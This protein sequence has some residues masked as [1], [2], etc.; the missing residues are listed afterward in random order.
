MSGPADLQSFLNPLV[1]T[2]IQVAIFA[3][4]ILVPLFLVLW[5]WKTWVV[6]VRA[7]FFSSQKYVV[8]ELKIPK[9]ISK[10]PLAMELFI[11]SLYQTGGEGTPYDKFWL[12][13][14]RPWFSLEIAS[15][16]GQVRFFIW[17]RDSFRNLIESQLYGQ[18]PDIEI[19]KVEDYSSK[20]NFNWADHDM[21]ACDFKKAAATHLPI[22]TYVNYGLDKDPKEEV[23]IDPITS[24]LEFLGSIG[25]GEQVWIQIVIRAHKKEWIK[26]GTWFEKVDWSHAA[27]LDIDKI[28]KRDDK[29]KKE[30]EINLADFS[31]TKGER[32]KV[33]AIEK[34][35][36][37]LPFDSG[38]RVLYVARKDSYKGGV[39]PG[40]AGSFRQ[41]NAPNLNGFAPENSTSYDY[42]WQ[43]F[44]GVRTMKKKEKMMFLYRNRSF[45]YPEFFPDGYSHTN[46]ILTTEELATIYHFPGDVSR[47]P[48]LS[49]IAA[50]R[51]EPP[52]NLPI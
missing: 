32:D 28:M 48:N 29:K 40:I 50:K 4:F 38:I 34:N 16:E 15:L 41:Y 42:P 26:P 47:T 24:V 11:T 5:F 39:I 2:I 13:K 9:G 45:F 17:T 20:L 7:L 36:A 10:S 8:L 46:F 21:W 37:K 23:K 35:V 52:A 44:T 33:E 25:R 12:G 43:D 6:Y 18:F 22:K 1:G 27:K 31:M 30:G 14:T 3:A 51:L 49:R 19:N